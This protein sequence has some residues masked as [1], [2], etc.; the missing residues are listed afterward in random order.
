MTKSMPIIMNHALSTEQ[1]EDARRTLG[2]EA[3]PALP[4]DLGAQWAA[5]DPHG[6]LD[7]ALV[8]AV[9]S[10]VRDVAASGDPVLVQGEAGVTHAVVDRLQ[11]LGYVPVY[12]TTARDVVEQRLP[13][14]RTETR[15]VFRHVQFRAFP[16]PD[17]RRVD[18]AAPEAAEEER[19]D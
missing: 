3:F 10:W 19:D 18:G 6:A 1:A 14:G 4:S 13:D 9:V 12:A 15:R 7:L 2:V 17:D 8:A 16:R 5:V 11:A